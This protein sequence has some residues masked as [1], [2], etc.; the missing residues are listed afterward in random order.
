MPY[1]RAGTRP[2]LPLCPAKVI[3]RIQ[4]AIRTQVVIRQPANPFQT[5]TGHLR[6]IAHIL[7]ARITSRR[8]VTQ[9]AAFVIPIAAMNA[10]VIL[11]KTQCSVCRAFGVRWGNSKTV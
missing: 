3:I 10:D 7:A 2:G 8:L 11:M 6:H 5:N 1:P 4:A 9:T